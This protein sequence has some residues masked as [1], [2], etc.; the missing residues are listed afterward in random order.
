[1]GQFKPISLHWSKTLLKERQE[2]RW[3][4]ISCPMVRGLNALAVS[5]L[6][7]N[8]NSTARRNWLALWAS[9]H[10]SRTEPGRSI[11]VELRDCPRAAL[12]IPAQIANAA[13]LP[14]RQ[15]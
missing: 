10:I 7:D 9:N 4:S 13:F 2:A 14:L 12:K 5:R 15:R 11:A 8:P 6:T 1:M 3:D